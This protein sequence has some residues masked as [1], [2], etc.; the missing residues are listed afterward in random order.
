MDNQLAL[1]PPA[2][3]KQPGQPDARR[4]S[5]RKPDCRLNEP[6]MPRQDRHAAAD[7]RRAMLIQIADWLNVEH[8][9]R[10]QPAPDGA[11]SLAYAADYCQLAG[12]YLPH[13]WW[14]EAALRELQTIDDPDDLPDVSVHAMATSG[15]ADWLREHGAGF[16]W[17]Q[18]D[19]AA[20]LQ[21]AAN[22]G[23]IGLISTA[24]H[25][26]VVVPEDRA[27][28]AARDAG[29]QLTDPLQSDAGA[30]NHRHGSPGPHW[31]RGAD[32]AFWVHD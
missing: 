24:R 15:L 18:V 26:S 2:A 8:S 17:R 7:A 20:A 1:R 3:Y 10:Y 28:A 32:A 12:V 16:G 21:S 27:H 22:H 6:N 14:T 4:N 30:S 23:G 5:P 13:A 9:V 19:D 29:G 11:R 25:V 31:W